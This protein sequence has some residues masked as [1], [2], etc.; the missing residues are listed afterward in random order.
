VK[1]TTHESGPP[2]P[3]AG[4]IV[5]DETPSRAGSLPGAPDKKA[6]ECRRIVAARAGV[7]RSEQPAL[8]RRN[9][10]LT[11][12]IQPENARPAAVIRES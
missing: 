7:I 11:P 12:S 8:P 4:S 3:A 9:A 2:P 6:F 5:T 1:T 10:T